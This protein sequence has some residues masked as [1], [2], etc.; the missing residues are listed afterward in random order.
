MIRKAQCACGRVSA[1]VNG[2]PTKVL[3][4]HCDYCQRRTGSIFGV[5]CYFLHDQVLELNG[6]TKVFSKS[7]NSIGIQY[8]FCP[9]CGTTVHWTYGEAMEAAYPGMS[10]FRGFAV[11]CFVDKAFPAPSRE[12]QRQYAHRWLPEVPRVETFDGFPDASTT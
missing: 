3:M 11:G 12:L 8:E 2:D 5:T 6:E 7:A 1:V 10:K 4:C 9:N